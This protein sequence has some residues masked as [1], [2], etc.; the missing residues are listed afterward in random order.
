MPGEARGEQGPACVR[1]R[2]AGCQGAKV[3]EVEEQEQDV[4]EQEE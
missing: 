1:Q 4:G 3:Q 2:Q